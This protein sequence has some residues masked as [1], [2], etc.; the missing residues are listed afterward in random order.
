MRFLEGLLALGAAAPAVYAAF[1]SAA[2]I[3][4]RGFDSIETRGVT[5]IASVLPRAGVTK[6]N[7]ASDW[8]NI[9]AG[10]ATCQPVG[11]IFARGTFDE[12]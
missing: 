11:I 7:T 6:E 10:K 2:P 4:E 5:D 9:I 1:V 3:H 12:G 8:D